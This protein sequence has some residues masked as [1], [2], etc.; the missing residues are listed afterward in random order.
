[1]TYK[2]PGIYLRDLTPPQPADPLIETAL[3]AFIG[4]TEFAPENG[5]FQPFRIKTLA[6][7]ESLFGGNYQP[8][9]YFADVLPDGETLIAT[10]PDRRFFLYESLQLY[11][12]NG[13][14]DCFI[15][16]VGGYEDLITL[17]EAGGTTA[18]GLLGGVKALE[19]ADGVTL[20]LF[21]DA[22]GLSDLTELG[23]LHMTA[24]AHCGKAKNCF[25]IADLKNHD[26]FLTA[27][28]R[29][30]DSLGNNYLQY[31]AAYFPWIYSLYDHQFHFY[32]LK[33][34]IKDGE[35]LTP[36]T[37]YSIFSGNVSSAEAQKHWELIAEVLRQGQYV[38]TIAGLVH[39]SSLNR[40]HFH[41]LETRWRS[42]YE[43]ILIPT[44]EERKVLF[45]KALLWISEVALVLPRLDNQLSDVLD[46]YIFIRKTDK[47]YIAALEKLIALYKAASMYDFLF[48]QQNFDEI[49]EI[50]SDLNGT[51]WIRTAVVPHIPAFS[52]W[53][54]GE[55]EGETPFLESLVKHLLLV[56]KPI[57][58]ALKGL[59]DLALAQE[60]SAES[61]L[62]SLHPF[63]SKVKASLSLQLKKMPPS[64][65]VAG[66]IVRTDATKG[67]WK[68]PANEQIKSTLGPCIELDDSDQ[69]S[70]NVHPTG[71]SVNVIRSI[72]GRGTLIWGAR[73]LA[74]NDNE[75]RYVPVR[76]YFSFV[77][78]FVSQSAE[79]F[80]FEPNDA[81][82]WMRFRLMLD[83]FLRAQW[84]QGALVG[85]TTNEAYYVS[86]GLGETM[87]SQ[88]ILEGRLIAEIG[89]AAV[90]PAE[91]IVI[92]YTCRM[93][94]S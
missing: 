59:F 28:D 5:D 70:L 83:N 11:F 67:V 10:G 92:H 29:F 94:T 21:P 86:V 91:F 25:L 87:T 36:V 53:A 17:G 77:E 16:S 31:G 27:V 49:H 8:D 58:Q 65:A 52:D 15:V 81:N 66:V 93:E 3:P 69:E 76:R 9:S 84:R 34:R 45:E 30:R 79:Q 40:K 64:G 42:L 55:A 82:T 80:V 2:T 51:N 47:T 72:R 85:T 22:V 24:L 32:E 1:M 18:S 41:L 14:G 62:F 46:D 35:T 60:L 20:V 7:F 68:A 88:D 90:R 61:Q 75:W 38:N 44:D 37:D 50:F 89:L 78:D 74:G 48:P 23:Q 54:E 13:G 12:D 26:R 19:K 56:A 43:A 71:K 73:T 33:F 39:D 63:F 6:H 57:L 4:Y